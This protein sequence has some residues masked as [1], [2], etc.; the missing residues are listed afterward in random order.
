MRAILVENGGGGAFLAPASA[1]RRLLF[2][3]IAFALPCAA[4]DAGALRAQHAALE[5]KLAASDFDRPLHVE[6]KA[7]GGKHHGDVYAVVGHPFDQ[8]ARAL[9]QPQHW[10]DILS[11][12]VNVKYCAAA[13]DARGGAISALVTRKARQPMQS[14]HQVDF[15]FKVAA[16]GADYLEVSMRA[17]EGPVGTSDYHIALQAAPLASRKTFLHFSYEYALGLAARIAMDA[18]LATSGR[19]KVGFSVMERRPDGQPVYVDGVRGVLE[20]SA[21]RHY[22][23][24]EAFLDSLDAPAGE[25]LEARLNGWYDA[26]S[27]YPQLREEVGRAEYVAMKR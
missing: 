20:R 1:M 6:S 24:I 4:Q 21:M 8:V 17:P 11:L 26:V 18:Y 27:R 3:A 12:Q 13:K 22:L 25:R 10:C 19:D 16:A 23:A 7:D 15:A 2:L 14:G 9:A 5:E